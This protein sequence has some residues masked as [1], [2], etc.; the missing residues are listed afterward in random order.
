M[1]NAIIRHAISSKQLT[2]KNAAYGMHLQ[3][4]TTLYMPH[5]VAIVAKGL[6]TYDYIVQ[7]RERERSLGPT[8]DC[9]VCKRKV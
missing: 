3:L 7:R 1:L 4:D 6:S 8:S 9:I 5:F 2:T